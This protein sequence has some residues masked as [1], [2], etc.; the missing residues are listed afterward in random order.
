MAGWRGYEER[1]IEPVRIDEI[2][3]QPTPPQKT[4]T[5][6]AAVTPGRI[7]HRCLRNL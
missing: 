4:G 2:S 7:A 5:P 1:E 6:G 3:E